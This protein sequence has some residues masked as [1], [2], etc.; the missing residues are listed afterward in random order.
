MRP[1]IGG[2]FALAML[3][4][5]WTFA[6]ETTDTSPPPVVVRERTVYV[7]YEKL[8]ETF[9]KEGRGVFL[10]YEE[11][12]K[13]WNAAQ[14]KKEEKKEL[15]PPA[16]AAVTG[17]AYAGKAGEKAVRFEVTFTVRAL[18][19][20]WAEV[21]LPLKNVAVETA[22]VSDPAAVFAPQGDGYVLIAPRP[23]EYTLTLSFAVRVEES[24]GRR[25]IAFGI[26]PTAVSRL[27]LELPGKDLRVDVEP[28]MAATVTEAQGENTRL[29]AFIGNSNRVAVTWRPPEDKVEKGEALVIASQAVQAELGERILRLKTACAYRI[30]R[31]ETDTFRV[32]LP[33]DMRLLSVKGENIRE[34]TTE[35]GIL[36]VRLHSPVKDSYALALR[37]ERI[38]E[39]TPEDLS[40]PFP[41]TLGTMREDGYVT[42][43]HEPALRV[44]IDR[45][46]GLSQIDARE[47][48]QAMRSTPLLAGFRYLAH[49]L[50]LNLKIER[51]QPQIRSQ[52][53]MVAS[54]GQDED[55]LSGW[56]DYQ[57]AKVGIFVVRLK[58]P[59]RWE[60]AS[61][62]DKATVEDFQVATEG[63]YKVLTAN[64]KNQALGEFRLPFRLTAPGSG[65]AP[66]TAT[67]EPVQVLETQQDRGTFGVSAPK[68]FKLTTLERIG[69]AS[70]NVQLLHASGL[71]GQLP[72]DHDLPLAYTY[73]QTPASV[74][75]QLERRKTEIRVTGFH[76]VTVADSG[77]KIAHELKYFIEFA[78]TDRITFSLP[79]ELDDV[80]H[81]KCANLKEKK[82]LRETDGRSVWELT[83]QDKLLGPLSVLISHEKDLKKVEADQTHDIALPLVRA[84]EVESHQGYVTICKDGS[85]EIEPQTPKNLE[86]IESVQLPG[87][88]RQGNLYLAYR[89]FQP[90]YA[91]TL[92]LKRHAPVELA[93]TVVNLLRLSAV[94][95]RERKMSVR[96]VFFVE[97]RGEQFLELTL[98]ASAQ[99]RALAVKRTP[100]TPKV[101][102]DGVTLI[103]LA[104]GGAGT[105]FPVDL[106]YSQPLAENGEMGAFG[107][108]NLEGPRLPAT[109]PVNKTEVDLFVPKD[110]SYWGFGGTLHPRT[111]A[112]SNTLAWL[113]GGDQRTVAVYGH[114][115]RM[116]DQ[117][118]GQFPTEGRLLR[119]ETLAPVA[120]LGFSYCGNKLVVFLD[121]MLALL[122][123]GAGATLIRAAKL[124]RLWVGLGAVLI[125]L[126][127]MWYVNGDAKE[128]WAAAAI[129]GGLLAAA[130]LTIALKRRWHEWR[131]LLIRTAP[132]PFLEEAPEKPVPAEPETAPEEQ[133]SGGEEG[134]KD[135]GQRSANS[136]QTSDPSDH[137]DPSDKS[138]RKKR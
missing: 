132:D 20:K 62:G 58:F 59:A 51:V 93:K 121:A 32:K 103:E 31:Q 87:E 8:K 115:F 15:K 117:P 105:S 19:E 16:D 50:T 82:R 102:R 17:G 70:G 9:E 136:D 91:L 77:L 60:P 61:V 7:P 66:G 25:R 80:F 68:A 75:L 128:P 69:A 65:T 29:M 64:L 118:L 55:A 30:E 45:S 27:E 122:V 22:N 113:T 99:L 10:P 74:K 73:T 126:L 3:G 104:A 94:V 37:F 41:S 63:A 43:A 86:A 106:V 138:H 111:A 21:Q 135:S 112:H 78:A 28:K 24:T 125:P 52:A 108:L 107:T 18:A 110:Y 40:I 47:L 119:F 42:L 53:T 35:D 49:P 130:L 88:L 57:I 84:E 120:K 83:L 100:V 48:P 116:P 11:F 46:A 98:P 89:F 123:F 114:P 44:R 2:L 5:T 90:D 67:L 76:V 13:L 81:A 127:L 4:A 137:P 96:A 36:A 131:E 1:F 72:Q 71:L 97:T 79:T 26:P 12:L 101:R 56:V 134:P 133:R 23:G 34:W 92:K 54:L 85:L 129:G 124:S 39:K 6:Q 33:A 14:P 38:L 109:V 95:S